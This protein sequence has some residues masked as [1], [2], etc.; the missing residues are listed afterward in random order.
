MY[1]VTKIFQERFNLFA[2]VLLTILSITVYSTSLKNS[3]ALDDEELIIKNEYIKE[4]KNIPLFFISTKTLSTTGQGEIA[5]RPLETTS[6]AVDYFLWKLNPLGY[7]LTSLFFHILNSIL[8]CFL[9]NILQKDKIISLL[10]A[11]IFAVHPVHVEN[12]AFIGARSYLISTF[13]YLLSF[14]MYCTSYDSDKKMYQLIISMICFAMALLS[15]ELAITMS[16]IIILYDALFQREERFIDKLRYRHTPFLVIAILYLL[17]RQSVLPGLAQNPYL[18][19][20]LYYTM[21]TEIQG[22]TYYYIKNLIFPFPSNLYF[23]IYNLNLPIVT[24]LFDLK[25]ISSLVVVVLCLSLAFIY[26]RKRKEVS[27]FILWFFIAL[28]PFLN[29]IPINTLFANR[30]LY[31]PSI[32]FCFIL[33]FIF[34]TTYIKYDRVSLKLFSFI[35]LVIII[36]YYSLITFKENRTWTD[37]YSLWSATV[38]RTP[39]NDVAHY[40]LGNSFLKEGELDRAEAEYREALRLNPVLAL[41]ISNLGAVHQRRGLHDLAISEFEKAIQIKPNLSEAYFALGYSLEKTGKAKLAMEVYLKVFELN[42]EIVGK[43]NKGLLAKIDIA[44]GIEYY[45]QGF[46]DEAILAYKEALKIDP[47]NDKVYTNVGLVYE[48]EGLLNEAINN[49]K[50]ALE[51]NPIQLEARNNL[52]NLYYRKGLFREA[53]REYEAALQVKPSSGDIHLNIGIVYLNGFKEEEMAL[54]HLKEVLKTDID[55][56]G[57]M[58]ALKLIKDLEGNKKPGKRK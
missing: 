54:F 40:N 12:V 56:S 1:N 25:A 38:K 7:H 11:L 58:L 5:Y 2:I 53:I 19:G 8:V 39:D 6:F 17:L 16:A 34:R 30:F 23:V 15:K 28:L 32:G 44:K 3:F 4:L 20:N 41:A 36:L 18:A 24:S 50:K 21:L 10:A 49:Y 26:C 51:I 27:F 57:K 52:A 14:Y 33:A 31:L 35:I 13:F 45:T 22:L 29:I 43:H 46:L 47:Q 9:F 55:Q 37:D 42:P 48:S